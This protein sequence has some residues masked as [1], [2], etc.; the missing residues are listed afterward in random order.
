MKKLFMMAIV[1]F[2]FN[3][4]WGQFTA[5][6]AKSSTSDLSIYK[7]FENALNAI[8]AES[9]TVNQKLESEK[10]EVENA[11]EELENRK[12]E[13]IK[14]QQTLDSYKVEVQA[15]LQLLENKEA[16]VEKYQKFVSDNKTLIKSEKTTQ[17]DS[18]AMVSDDV[19]LL[20][21]N[22]T[23]ELE[24]ANN[25][26]E[27][28]KTKLFEAEQMVKEKKLEAK[29]AENTIAD[30][31]AAVDSLKQKDKEIINPLL[32]RIAQLAIDT[33]EI[34]ARE[35]LGLGLDDSIVNARGS[36][37]YKKQCTDSITKYIDRRKDLETTRKDT[38]DINA[39]NKEMNDIDEKITVFNWAKD[40]Y[41]AVNSLDKHPKISARIAPTKSIIAA[42]RFFYDKTDNRKNLV[43]INN[44]AIQSNLKDIYKI[45]TEVVSGIFPFFTKRIPIKFSLGTTIDQNNLDNEEEK[46]ASKILSGGETVK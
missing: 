26:V 31:R 30:K 12:K 40:F 24:A 46:V 37:Y 38:V 34:I 20:L 13:V 4:S 7:E 19:L 22:K 41:D 11:K 8:K 28:L 33:T 5:P 43:F 21:K 39:F 17:R 9:G 1:V 16:E 2:L 36:Y 35:V 32:K 44:S 42:R 15:A 6:F 10:E 14:S 23:I 25:D 3:N 29:E 45:S 27:N 18:S